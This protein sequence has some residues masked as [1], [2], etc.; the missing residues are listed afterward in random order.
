ML[1]TSRAKAVFATEGDLCQTF[2]KQ[3][4][5]G[6]TAYPETAGWDILLVRD[7]DGY[8][9]GIQ[10]KLTL[11]AKV[12]EQSMEHS[13]HSAASEG[14]DFRAILI[15]WG[16]TS[17]L[18]AIAR[19]LGFTVIEMRDREMFKEEQNRYGFKAR[20]IKK[21]MPDLPDFSVYWGSRLEWFDRAPSKRERLPEYVPDVKAGVQSPVQ[22]SEWKIKAIK[23]CVIVEK[24]GFVVRKDFEYLKIDHRRF[25]TSNNQGWL[26]QGTVRGQWIAGVLPQDL[27]KQHPKNYLQIEA[28]FPIWGKGL[29]G[30]LL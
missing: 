11:N 16:C 28:D 3:L 26:Q 6:W 14:P 30:E 17:G 5:K 7:V 9:I 22:L 24:R 15:P 23:I 8:Q 13:Y 2:I 19:A 29:E 20:N 25:L 18:L 4:P 10:A 27:R 21:F 1:A 12:L